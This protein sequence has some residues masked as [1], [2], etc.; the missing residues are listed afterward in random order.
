MAIIT[1][2]I[3]FAA[4]RSGNSQLTTSA[5]IASDVLNIIASVVATLLSFASHRSS[6]RPSTV[7]V[8]YLSTQALLLLPRLRT[9]WLISPNSSTA[10]S[11]TAIYVATITS[12][13]AESAEEKP[14]QTKENPASKEPY[15]GFW[16]RTSFA[17]MLD[18]FRLGN[19]NIISQSDLP[20]LDDQ[21]QSHLLR[22]RLLAEWKPGMGKTLLSPNNFV[23]LLIKSTE[24]YTK[25]RSLFYATMRLLFPLLLSTVIP[26]LCQTVFT[27]A[28]T[29]MINATVKYIDQ[30]D[31]SPNYGKGL[32][33]AWALVYLGLAVRVQSYNSI[34]LNQA[35][36]P[37]ISLS[38]FQYKMNRVLATARGALL[39]I[40]HHHSMRTRVANSGEITAVTLMGTDV[41]RIANGLQFLGGVWASILDI[42]IACWL[43]ERQL[44]LACLAPIILTLRECS[45]HLKER[46]DLTDRI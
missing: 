12:L 5:S 27:F 32:I 33:G 28:Q 15:L 9:I 3:A 1:T 13:V 37:Q 44:S 16:N 19:A 18:I 23:L 29:F 20:A 25:H 36:G 22:D 26:R 34:S 45:R 43:L 30:H 42:G 4:S 39:A 2:Q 7:L 14:S 24:T 35:N 46:F 31:A 17:W 38:A 8:L 41:Q 6:S 21:L 11:I 40:V 10:A